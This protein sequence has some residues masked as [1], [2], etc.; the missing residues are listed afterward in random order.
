MEIVKFVSFVVRLGIILAL[1]GQLKFCT[2]QLMG[3][4]GEKT[5]KGMISYSKYTRM[6]LVLLHQRGNRSFKLM[7]FS[8]SIYYSIPWFYSI[9]GGI[10]VSRI[11][12]PVGFLFVQSYKLAFSKK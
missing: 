2:L 11:S 1:M 3:M 6:L 10:T 4:A 7:K 5:Q 8:S 12:M 9:R